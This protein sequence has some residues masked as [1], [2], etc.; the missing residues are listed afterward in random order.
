MEEENDEDSEYY[1]DYF[2]EVLEETEKDDRDEIVIFEEGSILSFKNIVLIV[3]NQKWR[4]LISCTTMLYF[5]VIIYGAGF[6][7]PP[8]SKV[9]IYVPLCIDILYTVKVLLTSIYKSWS[10]LNRVCVFPVQSNFHLTLDAISI[11]PLDWAMFLFHDLSGNN[12]EL[13]YFRFNRLFRLLELHNF[14]CK[15]SF[16]SLN[17]NIVSDNTNIKY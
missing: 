15:Y 17:F 7:E 10:Q 1:Q 4:T 5:F 11:V 2:E 8:I 9:E 13:A 6:A 3:F 14:F 12:S 16:L